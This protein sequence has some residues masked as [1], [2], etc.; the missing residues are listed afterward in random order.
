M[1]TNTPAMPAQPT[2]QRNPLFAL[3][4]QLLSQQYQQAANPAMAF[5]NASQQQQFGNQLQNQQLQN[6]MGP[7]YNPA[8]GQAQNQAALASY[9][10][11]LQRPPGPA[12][13]QASTPYQAP[14]QPTQ[15]TPRRGVGGDP[16]DR[17]TFN[18]LR[19]T[20]RVVDVGQ[21]GAMGLGG[22]GPQPVNQGGNGQQEMPPLE[23]LMAMLQQGQGQ[24]GRR[25]PG[26]SGPGHFGRGFQL[27]QGP[28]ERPQ[29]MQDRIDARGRR[30]ALN[31][32]G[33][34]FQSLVPFAS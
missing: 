21:A 34:L 31:G 3:Y 7:M 30:N 10:A 13:M 32:I 27:N 23:Q 15:A 22:A 11:R 26:Y 2:Q 1:P 24:G 12:T 29:A 28:A 8:M 6:V 18:N 14:Q 25:M 17:Q 5:Q 4:D 33:G 20:G 16:G 19:N 9:Q